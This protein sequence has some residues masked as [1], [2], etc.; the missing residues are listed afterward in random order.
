VSGKECSVF[1]TELESVIGA[2]H[3]DDRAVSLRDVCVSDA[4]MF[5]KFGHFEYDI[6]SHHYVIRDIV[7]E[8][9][10]PSLLRHISKK[11]ITLTPL[12]LRNIALDIVEG[13]SDD[14]ASIT[15]KGSLHFINTFERDGSSTYTP[16]SVL[17]NIGLDP[18]LMVP[19]EGGVTFEF[20]DGKVYLRDLSNCFSTG[21]RSH[22][23]FP[24]DSNAIDWSGTCSIDLKMK[25]Y[26]LFKIAQPF[27]LNISGTV[28]EPIFELKK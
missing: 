5:C 22:F 25:Q 6:A 8:E 7:G 18:G 3:V 17:S 2:V 26:V 11:N 28:S 10:R 9:I 19:V 16:F 4:A 23:Y 15:G 13:D 12:L 24:Q 1:D 20:L 14:V 21:K 27:T